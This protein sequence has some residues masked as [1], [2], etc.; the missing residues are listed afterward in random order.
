MPITSDWHIHT[1]HSCDQASLQ[2][3]D[4]IAGA[5]EQGIADLGIT[6]HL[7]TPYNL[8]DL[9]ASRQEFLAAAPSG[10]LHFGVE[11][12]CVTRWELEEIARGQH[13]E[14]VYGIRQGG[15]PEGPL[16]IGLEQEH[17]AALGIEYVVGGA[18][19]PLYVPLERE[20][21]IRD[22]HRQNMF[23]A[24]HP[25]VD[26]VAHPW[27]WMGAWQDADGRYTTDPW[28]GDFRVIPQ[29]L[30]QEFAAAV[31]EGEKVVEINLGA[32]VLSRAYPERFQRQ[33]LEYL[34]WLRERGVRMCVG[35]DCHGARY[36]MDFPR[37][38]ELLAS[39]GIKDAE[40]W[41]L[42]PRP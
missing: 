34:A 6:D 29:S 23:L 3:A 25:L 10:R 15:P 41:R 16:A 11:V 7:H 36:Q 17:L 18:H 21:V 20:A 2:T 33:Y 22:Y 35:S 14:P 39:V 19:W 4:L 5:R 27:W 30:H 26:I 38:A 13:A 40:L 9:A 37:A 42:P 1:H 8:P 32:V 12:S 31:R 28:L 24:T